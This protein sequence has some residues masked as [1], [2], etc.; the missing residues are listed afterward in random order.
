MPTVLGSS[1]VGGSF[2]SQSMRKQIKEGRTNELKMDM[3]LS[4][5]GYQL[6][7]DGPLQQTKASWG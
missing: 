7:I 6:S 5:F 1:R 4:F 3:N 2:M